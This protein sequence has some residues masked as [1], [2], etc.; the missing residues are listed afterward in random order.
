VREVAAS[1]GQRLGREP[2]F[3]GQEMDTSCLGDARESHRLFGQPTVG[4]EQ[5]M[6]WVANW[7][8]AGGEYLGKPTHFDR[9]DG[10]Y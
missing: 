2:V 8:R 3:C 7:V 9:R 4:V 5:M 10:K 6:D 1:F